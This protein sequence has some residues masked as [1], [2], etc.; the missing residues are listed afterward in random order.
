MSNDIQV[1]QDLESMFSK[2]N[3]I[4]QLKNTSGAQNSEQLEIHKCVI[5]NNYLKEIKTSISEVAEKIND[6]YD[7]I[8]Q[9]ETSETLEYG[10]LYSELLLD[11]RKEKDF[12]NTFGPYM[13]LWNLYAV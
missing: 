1:M 11:I 6:V 10:D 3:Y 5:L 4:I 2:L 8:Q 13:T 7:V 12:M 9:Y